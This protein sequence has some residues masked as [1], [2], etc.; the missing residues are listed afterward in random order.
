MFVSAG[1]SQR[2]G[3]RLPVVG[4]K[5]PSTTRGSQSDA[6]HHVPFEKIPGREIGDF[7]SEMEVAT[8]GPTDLLVL[9]NEQSV[10][11]Q[12]TDHSTER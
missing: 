7:R 1:V 11:K 5:E 4:W 8:R 12:S 9:G 2:R 3:S 10:E 6:S